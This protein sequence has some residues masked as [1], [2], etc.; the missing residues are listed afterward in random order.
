MASI[1]KRV[2][3]GGAVR[4]DVRWRVHGKARERAFPTRAAADAYRRKVEGDELVGSAIDPRRGM[5]IL[6]EY[7]EEWLATRR[8]V[9][10]RPLAPKTLELYRY[11]LDRHVLPELGRAKLAEIRPQTVRH[12]H[13]AVASASSDLQAAKA[14][15]LL[16]T[17]MATAVADERIAVNP[18]RVRG[19][20]V[21]HSKERPFVD[22]DVVLALA[23]AIEARYR[24]LVL[25]A[26][27]AGLRRGE[28]LALQR[29]DVDE[30]HRTVSVTR[31]AVETMH[32][33]RLVTPPKTGAGVRRVHLP[34]VVAEA[35]V[36]H[37]ADHVGPAADALLFTGPKGGPLRLATLQTAWT[38]ARDAVGIRGVTLHDLRHAAGTLAAQTGATTREL[39]ARLGHASPAAAMRYQHAAERR[40]VEIAVGLDALVEVAKLSPWATVSPIAGMGAGSRELEGHPRGPRR[41]A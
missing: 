11:L 7:S 30:V 6:D 41:L 17:I 27:L 34:N 23:D 36:A 13:G 29:G 38:D 32:G 21:E 16:S 26:G 22:A 9:D 4:Y 5:V 15:R 18:C 20:G 28:L 24:A 10:G 14:Y 31:Q 33:E 35:L 37:L 1:S 25:L 12:W 8:R 2:T 40:D 3:G 19:A 39:M